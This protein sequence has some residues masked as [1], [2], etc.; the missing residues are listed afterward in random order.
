MMRAKPQFFFVL[1]SAK[2]NIRRFISSEHKESHNDIELKQICRFINM[3]LS[4]FA[5]K[6]KTKHC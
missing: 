2:T 5:D 3:L 1:L 4:L 6:I